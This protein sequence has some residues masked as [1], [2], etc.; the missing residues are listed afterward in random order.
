MLKRS[1]RSKRLRFQI[2]SAKE[3]K[4]LMMKRKKNDVFSM[5]S[6]DSEESENDVE[7]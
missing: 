5:S 6:N 7:M 3:R 1:K 4:L 2:A